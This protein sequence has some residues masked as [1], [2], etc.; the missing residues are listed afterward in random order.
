M[1]L[2]ACKRTKVGNEKARADNEKDKDGKN[3]EKDRESERKRE[4][5]R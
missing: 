3:C 4:K 5:K 1:Q 2:S